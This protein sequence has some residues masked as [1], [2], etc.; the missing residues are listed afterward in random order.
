M[1]RLVGFD[2]NTKKAHDLYLE[3][4]ASQTIADGL[5][6]CFPL[7]AEDA[8]LLIFLQPCFPENFFKGFGQYVGMQDDEAAGIKFV[9]AKVK[10]MLEK[11]EDS[12]KGYT[13][14]VFEELLF[15]IAIHWAKENVMLRKMLGEK[16]TNPYIN[17]KQQ[18]A[19][20]NEL[21]ERFD[22]S[23]QEAKNMASNLLRFDKMLLE[24]EE[25]DNLFFWDDD[26][27][28]F[29]SNSLI[30]GINGLKGFTGEQ[31][32]Y[33][34]DYTCEIFSDIGMK[35]PIMLVGTKEGNRIANEVA[36]KKFA[37]KMADIIPSVPADDKYMQI[38][39]DIPDEDLPF[40]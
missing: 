31:M 36:A 34:Y 28:F 27:L 8:D 1:F 10:R 7:D 30:D 3:Q 37:E 16:K 20:A 15:V 35:P 2:E 32:G 29:F 40:N 24:D 33:G 14:D 38:P 21:M 22:Y 5:R 19:V 4:I 23:E 9:R 39:D 11:L 6:D 12:S 13:F 18:T 26:C 25:D 17:R